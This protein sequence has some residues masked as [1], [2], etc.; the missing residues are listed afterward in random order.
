MSS[1]PL[2]GRAAAGFRKRAASSAG[3]A[4]AADGPPPP[5]PCDKTPAA[6]REAAG[7][8]TVVGYGA[9][10]GAGTTLGLPGPASRAPGALS[11]SLAEIDLEAACQRRL[12]EIDYLE[13]GDLISPVEA[14]HRRRA[15]YS[16]LTAAMAD[17]RA[18]EAASGC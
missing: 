10:G 17:L 8:R 12:M 4:A 13:A 3:R 16:W 1:G 11:R 5:G 18:W 9:R 15:V 14:R 2:S 7:A 6:A